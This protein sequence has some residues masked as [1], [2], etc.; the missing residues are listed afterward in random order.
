[1]TGPDIHLGPPDI[2][3]SQIKNGSVFGEGNENETEQLYNLTIAEFQDEMGSGYMITQLGEIIQLHDNDDPLT[4]EE[5]DDRLE[6]AVAT[7]V[8]A[9]CDME[10]EF[11]QESD[12]KWG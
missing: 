10:L 4:T 2:V 1:M 5:I 6:S 12:E 9:F 11:E 7:V 8:K 3:W